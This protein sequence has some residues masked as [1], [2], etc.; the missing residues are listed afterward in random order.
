MVV[1]PR[2]PAMRADSEGER[3]KAKVSKYS[4]AYYGKHSKGELGWW[5]EDHWAAS[6]DETEKESVAN[7]F[8][9]NPR[10]VCRECGLSLVVLAGIGPSGI[11]KLRY[12]GD[13]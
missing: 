8:G 13:A 5:C 12:A 6:D 7:A 11:P 3:R 10:V 9:L 2:V 1:H 4:R